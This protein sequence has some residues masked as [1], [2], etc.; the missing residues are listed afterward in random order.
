MRQTKNIIF[1]PSN[2]IE[3]LNSLSSTK[4]LLRCKEALRLWKTDKYDLLVVSGGRTCKQEIQTIPAAD[5]MKQWLI[6]NKVDRNKILSEDKSLD[7][8]TN[9]HYSLKLLEENNIVFENL[10]VVSHWTHLKRIRTILWKNY[11]IRSTCI[12]VKYKLSLTEWLHEIIWL[13]YLLFDKTGNG[14]FEKK[15]RQKIKKR[16]SL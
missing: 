5:L 7:T 9:I 8:Y 2:D 4:T 6:S 10:T 15:V 14:F 16:A 12:P 3:S 1:V 13:F 11:K